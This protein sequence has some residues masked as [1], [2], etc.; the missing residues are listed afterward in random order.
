[1][2]IKIFLIVIG[3]IGYFVLM[4]QF[5]WAR[6]PSAIDLT[7][8]LKTEILHIDLKHPSNNPQQ[9]HIRK[10]LVYKNGEEAISFNYVTQT[11][12]RGLIQDVP[13]KA[14]SK[15][16]IRV[17]AICNQAGRGEKTFILP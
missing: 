3:I 17:Q 7:Y 16:V 4:P 13:L 10:I 9:H 15:D 8:D 2:K 11:N 14:K 6:P 5:A 12:A 1:M